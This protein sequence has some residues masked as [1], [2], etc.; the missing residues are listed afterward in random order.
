M[1]IN[2]LF[3]SVLFGCLLLAIPS[4]ANAEVMAI[5]RMNANDF[6]ASSASPFASTNGSEEYAASQFL[7]PETR[8]I[9][10]NYNTRTTELA[11][12][13]V[14][15]ATPNN[16]S[17]S[18]FGAS[19]ENESRDSVNNNNYHEFSVDIVDGNWTV[20]SL[21]FDYWVNAPLLPNGEPDLAFFDD[22]NNR[23]DATVYTNLDN[24]ESVVATRRYTPP[25]GDTNEPRIDNVTFGDLNNSPTLSRFVVN[26]CSCRR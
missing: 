2:K 9:A 4:I 15:S 26:Y 10:R 12:D 22:A 7:P 5:Y 24:Y 23:F 6:N 11:A 21:S 16:R 8:V 19:G 20:D 3:P 18:F 14:R 1:K 13:G 17:H 25:A